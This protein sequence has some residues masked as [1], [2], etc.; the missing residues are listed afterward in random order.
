MPARPANPTVH[1]AA[2]ALAT[3]GPA[4]AHVDVHADTARPPA[5]DVT[6]TFSAEPESPTAGNTALRV[7]LPAG[8]DPTAVTTADSDSRL[9]GGGA[10]HPR[11][12]HAEAGDEKGG[13]E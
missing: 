4:G 9:S 3:V 1:Q 6:V 11:R 7:V 2:L 10:L 8:I 12:D 5:P 13:E